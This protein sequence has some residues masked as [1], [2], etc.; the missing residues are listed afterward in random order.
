MRDDE[1]TMRLLRQ[2]GPFRALGEIELRSLCYL[3]KDAVVE[4][5]GELFAEGDA[6]EQ[7]FVVVAGAVD[8]VSRAPD[9]S[10][11]VRRTLGPGELFGELALFTGGAG[12]RRL[13][14]AV[15]HGTTRLGVLGYEPFLALVRAHPAVALALLRMQAERF[16]AV[17]LEYRGL[18]DE[19]GGGG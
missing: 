19:Q 6:A 14:G 8:I 10:L 16:L 3:M 12:G 18:R 9:G 4:D 2:A 5:G 7:A 15:A 13:A 1:A 11:R 17:E